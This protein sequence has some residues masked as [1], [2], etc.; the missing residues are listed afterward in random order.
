MITLPRKYIRTTTSQK[1][2]AAATD[3]KYVATLDLMRQIGN[4]ETLAEM[5]FWY[6]AND[7]DALED[8]VRKTLRLDGAM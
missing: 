6:A 2:K 4:W 8:D 1:V 7:F 3:G 5:F